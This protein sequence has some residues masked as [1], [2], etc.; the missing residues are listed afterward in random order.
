MRGNSNQIILRPATIRD[1]K[2]L[3]KWR[4]DPQTRLASRNQ[5]ELTFEEHLSWLKK[6][7]ASENRAIYIA[8]IAGAPVATARTDYANHEYELSWTV[9]RNF[10]GR[11]LE[12]QWLAPSP[13]KS[14]IRF[15][16]R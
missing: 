8:E 1:A 2:L 13:T 16:L 5:G 4:N 12:K 7:L 14:T 3:Y 15:S 11:E 10:A 6:S 9:A